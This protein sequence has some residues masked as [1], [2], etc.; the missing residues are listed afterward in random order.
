MSASLKWLPWP[1]QIESSMP[2]IFKMTFV[3]LTTT[4]Q[5]FMLLSQSA[6]LPPKLYLIR[7]IKRE[8]E[9]YRYRYIIIYTGYD[10][11][12]GLVN[13]SPELWTKYKCISKACI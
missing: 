12:G 7:W 13:F 10:N 5:S 8:S 11:V 2:Q 3:I 6:Q 1:T 4:V 9:R